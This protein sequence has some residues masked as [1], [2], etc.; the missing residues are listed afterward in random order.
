MKRFCIAMVALFVAGSTT[1]A[2]ESIGQRTQAL[3]DSA[4]NA[5]QWISVK[6]APV[7]VGRADQIQ[8]AADGASWFTFELTNEKKVKSARWMATALG[9][10]DLFLN[11]QL[12]G[13]EVLRPGFT[14]FAKTKRSFTYDITDAFVKKKGKQ[15]VFMAQVTPGWWADKIVTEGHLEGMYGKKCAFR[16]VIE[17]TFTDGT[18]QLYGTDCEHWRAAIAGPVTHAAIFDG[19]EYDAR[20]PSPIDSFTGNLT[21]RTSH[22]AHP[23]PNTAFEGEI[24]PSDGAEIY[25]RYDLTLRPV[26]AYVWQDIANAKPAEKKEDVEHGTVIVKREYADGEPLVVRPGETLVVD[27]G[28]N[29]AGVPSFVFKAKGGTVLT[30]LPGEILNDGNGAERRGMDGP[31]GSVHRRNL[32]THDHHFRLVYTFA[33]S[34]GNV[35]YTPRY[36]FFGYRYASITA[37]DEVVISSI[38]SIPVTSIA[39]NMETGTI[40]TGNKDINQLISNTLWGQR[41]NYLSVPT[42]CPQRD[43]RLGWMA[44]TQVFA[45][46]GTFFANT[47]RFFHK[48]M[49]DVR[50]SQSPT[51]AFTGVSPIAQYGGSPHDMMRLGWADA[52]II[53]PWTVWKQFAD[54]DI[55]NESWQS[56]D[57]FMQHI[58]ETKYCHDSLI[59]ENGNYQ[60]ADWLSYE[61]LESCTGKAFADAETR[62]QAADYWSYLSAS[63][64]AID[65]TMMRDMAR[66][67]GRDAARYQR[68]A[69]EAKAYMKTTFMNEDGRFKTEVLNTMQTPTLF[70]LKNN[71]VEGKARD[72]MLARLRQNFADHGNCL[73]TGFLGTSILMQT[74]T[75]NGMADIAYELLFQRKNPSW[76]YSIDNGAT[77][78][79]ERWNSYMKDSGLGPNGMN[80]F[81][82]YAYGC[83]CQWLWETA[84][85]IAADPQKPGFRHIIM[86]PIPD[87]RLG[88]LSAAYPS[89]AG[90]IKSEWHY[91]G[92]LWTW[93]F[94]IPEGCT[95]TVTLPNETT[96]KEYTAGTY[97]LSKLL[98][99]THQ[100]NLEPS[101]LRTA[102]P[103]TEFFQAPPQAARP[104][105]WWH[106]MDG[107]ITLDSIRKDLEWMNRAGIGG[108]HCFEAGMG[109]KNVVDNRLG[110]MSPE[111]RN[112]FRLA[113]NIADSL[114][115]ETAIAS[116]PGWSNTGGPWVKPEDAMKRL[117]WTETLAQGGKRIT[118][119]LPQP[120]ENRLYQDVRIIAQRVNSADL[121]MEQM[122]AR[123]TTNDIDKDGGWMQYEFCNPQTIKALRI[124][125]GHYRSIWAALPA[126]V[127]KH[128]QASDDGV[129]FRDVCDIPHG[130]IR[131]QTINIPP[132]RAK[133][134]R[135]V[136]DKAPAFTPELTLFTVPKVNHIEEKAGYASPSDMMDFTTEAL[137]SEATPLHDIVDLTDLTSADGVLQ[138]NAPKGCWRIFRFGYTLTGK[139][140]HPAPPDA[141]G[142]EVTKMDKDAFTRFL[143]Y[144]LDTYKETLGDD[145]SKLD[146]LLIDS[147]EAGWETWAPQLATEFE[148]RRGYSLWPWLPVLTGQIVESSERSEEFLYDWRTTIGELIG[149]CMYENAA[150]IAHDYGLKTYFEAHENG[151]LY[152]VDGMTVKS[153]ADIPMAAMWRL[154]DKQA[155]NSSGTMGESDIRESASVAHLYGK[156]FVAVE[157][158]TVNGYVGGAYTDYPGSLK[159][160]ADLEMAN[161]ANRFVIH[162]STHQPLDNVR[163]GLGLNFYGQWFNRH[164]TWAEQARAWT[165]YLARSCYMLQ[166]G[167]N[168]ADIL[169]YYG[170]DDVVTSLF[171][172]QT[173]DLPAGFN[174][175]YLNK[176]ALLDLIQYDGRYLTT[177]S[178]SQY[179]LLVVGKTC[180]HFSESVVRKIE[181]LRAQG[182]PIVCE[183]DDGLPLCPIAFPSGQYASVLASLTPDVSASDMTDLRFVH[184]TSPEAEVYWLNNRSETPRLLQV[185]FRVSGRKPK[186]W[187]PETGRT[188][189]VSYRIDNGKTTVS[190]DMLPSDALFVVFS[191][192]TE[193]QEYDVEKSQASVFCRID[194]PWEVTFF[195]S[196]A[197]A[198][199]GKPQAEGGKTIVVDHLGSYTE[200]DDADIRYYS[201][202]AIY[203][204]TFRLSKKDLSQGRFILDL[205]EVGCMADVI[206]NGQPI[207]TLW[208]APYRTDITDALRKGE[209]EIEIHVVN[210]WVNR[211]VGDQ[212]PDCEDPVTYTP[213]KFYE[214]ASPLLPAG[215]MGP[216]SI[217]K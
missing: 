58:Y 70:A 103:S 165:D 55:I 200:S 208:K 37:T 139:E 201:G 23:E 104:R 83:V 161:G 27:F 176:D 94:S 109:M 126:P 119:S 68:M 215:L 147:Y 217:L 108:F 87:K 44:D 209:N 196:S 117:V 92:D 203:R 202:T 159:S 10:F 36:T 207:A 14:H 7:A 107:N 155:F 163:P 138:W 194:S 167:R 13:E 18:K 88:H 63:Y 111:W 67:T 105:V 162:E 29:C 190:L 93:T 133:F 216:V 61:A 53:V 19:E 193:K 152:L 54:T 80:S 78:I 129:S 128:L 56:M 145:F 2:Q 189:E 112:A 198:L 30:C 60:W 122:G 211:I 174:Y 35:S 69:D 95:A 175:D 144:Y 115:M 50:D 62:R 158:M 210:Q 82:H 31:E 127:T 182:A 73:Q 154:S 188:E 89:A 15:N 32:R 140:N 24:L 65:A 64:W 156:P 1:M 184:R 97:T 79:W 173:P 113:I 20:I 90:L 131:N 169:Y 86:S 59:A 25:Q 149:E 164:E 45:E 187:H 199:Y 124:A 183:S 125:D 195:P 43:E 134:F 110:Y 102:V 4:W 66:A 172:H 157:S 132:T 57:R 52:G 77:T 99:L 168:V 74:L 40:T 204:N 75:D 186:L 71:L 42:D 48:W 11:G 17:L 85:G 84:A 38:R 96:S 3:N 171:G 135:V 150:R 206:I 46:T 12:V 114:G 81:N 197:P 8:R 34:P 177:P 179:S 137:S 213:V 192:K 141:T 170:E 118:L 148:Q 181:A 49:R 100:A 130:S 76:L 180:R 16:A 214:A 106:W 151:R 178:G 22:L 121:T 98:P 51:G 185:T 143:T 166:Q 28:Q 212:Q 153:K 72:E 123:L 41:S 26:K 160:T 5:S 21:P 191:E 101:N 33:D 120:Q 6:D 116:C 91:E 146:Y 142:L 205:G 39:Q 136:F 9:V 47:D